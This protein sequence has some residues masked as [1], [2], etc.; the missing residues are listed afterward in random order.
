[1]PVH[2]VAMAFFLGSVLQLLE[3]LR[4]LRSG[5]SA[6]Q[7][8]VDVPSMDYIQE[9]RGQMSALRETFS[10]NPADVLLLQEDLRA[11]RSGPIASLLGLM[12]KASDF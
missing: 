7:P 10:V 1:M 6:L 12:D 11:L 3:D 8:G 5:R 9:L 2:F 4:A